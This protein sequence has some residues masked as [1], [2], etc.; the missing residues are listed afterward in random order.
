MKVLYITHYIIGHETD[1][2]ISIR[3]KGAD[4]HVV[5][6]TDGGPHFAQLQAAGIPVEK[7]PF[8]SRYDR[9]R[10]C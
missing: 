10:S 8:S 5:T 9:A 2:I 1:T 3:D 4:V 6:G 7:L